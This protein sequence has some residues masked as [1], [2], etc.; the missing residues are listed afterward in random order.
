M[1][2]DEV[3]VVCQRYSLSSPI[4]YYP[5]RNHHCFFSCAKSQCTCLVSKNS[6]RSSSPSSLAPP[7]RERALA[8]VRSFGGP[9]LES[10]ALNNLAG[11]L[12]YLGDFNGALAYA[13]AGYQLQQDL[14][15]NPC[16]IAHS[17]SWVSC[18]RGDY[19]EALDY[20]NQAL[21]LGGDSLTHRSFG[22]LARGDALGG[23]GRCDEAQRA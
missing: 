23:L 15:I 7:L 12:L 3:V 21:D 2:L 5:Y 1:A 11:N 17:L 16:V 20:A 14:G 4:S 13:L 9:E 8:L 18:H 19:A 22:L 10:Y 6:S